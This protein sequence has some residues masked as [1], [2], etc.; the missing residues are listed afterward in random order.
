MFAN[1]TNA[2]LITKS[3]VAGIQIEVIYMMLTVLSYVIKAVGTLPIDVKCVL[4]GR[5]G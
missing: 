2:H 4:V 5:Y 3:I 1:V